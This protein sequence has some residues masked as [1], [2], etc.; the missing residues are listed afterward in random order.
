M[1]GSFSDFNRGGR[2]VSVPKKAFMRT[3]IG[4][5]A[6][7]C[8]GAPLVL[9]LPGPQPERSDLWAAVIFGALF[10]GWIGFASS[11]CILFVTKIREFATRSFSRAFVTYVLFG[12]ISGGAALFWFGDGFAMAFALALEGTVLGVLIGTILAL[13]IAITSRRFSS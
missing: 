5:L 3:V 9:L 7:A 11:V 2:V 10:G 13:F 8:L 1:L 4:T 12:A 6:G